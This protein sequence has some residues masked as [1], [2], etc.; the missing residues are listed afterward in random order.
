MKL[1]AIAL[2]IA[3][4]PLAYSCGDSSGN[5]EGGSLE[6]PLNKYSGGQTGAGALE[7]GVISKFVT[8]AASLPTC[9][10]A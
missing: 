10:L 6:D 2:I 1:N 5:A 8:T 9:N 3:I 4:I 7:S